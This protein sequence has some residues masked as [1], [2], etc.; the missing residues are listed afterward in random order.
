[1]EKQG[2]KWH[3]I[4]V[5]GTGFCKIHNVKKKEFLL[6]CQTH[7]T[8]LL[9]SICVRER[10]TKIEKKEQIERLKRTIRTHRRE[11]K[12]LQEEIKGLK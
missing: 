12:E 7:E 4:E 10:N 5:G 1:M 8:G 11:I 3:G 9:C 6:N 2:K